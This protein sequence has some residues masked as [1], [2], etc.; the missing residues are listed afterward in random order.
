MSYPCDYHHDCRCLGS[1]FCWTESS[2]GQMQAVMCPAFTP[3]SGPEQKAC[4]CVACEHWPRS[5]SSFLSIILLRLLL[6][7]ASLSISVSMV[8]WAFLSPLQYHPLDWELCIYPYFM[9][10]Y[11]YTLA[12]WCK[13][14]TH[15]KRS[16]CWEW[17]KAGGEGDDRGWN[18]WMASLTLW[19]WVWANSR[20][21]WCTG[22]PGMLHFMESQRVRHDWMTELNWCH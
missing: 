1:V 10:T 6:L 9:F 16:W 3:I 22:R 13:G 18:G 2:L 8:T 5:S 19:T 20:S 11:L 12:T 14:L 15:W 4:E 21:W 17:L 7:D